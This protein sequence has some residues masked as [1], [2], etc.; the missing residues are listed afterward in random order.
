MTGAVTD[1]CKVNNDKLIIN[2]KG[3]IQSVKPIKKI[4]CFTKE[5]RF[6]VNEKQKINLEPDKRH[7][8]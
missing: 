5:A 4:L 6:V 2:E 8:V 1:D 7:R 3:I